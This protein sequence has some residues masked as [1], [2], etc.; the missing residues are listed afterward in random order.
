MSRYNYSQGEARDCVSEMRNL[1]SPLRLLQ[2]KVPTRSMGTRKP[3]AEYGNQETKRG[4]REPGKSSIAA[5]TR[6][7]ASPKNRSWFLGE[8]TPAMLVGLGGGGLC[9]FY[10]SPCFFSMRVQVSRKDTVRL[11]TGRA[12]VLSRSAQK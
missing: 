11:Y 1:T 5:P 7:K 12:G 2:D 9:V 6:E 4:A 10:P 8:A 3:N